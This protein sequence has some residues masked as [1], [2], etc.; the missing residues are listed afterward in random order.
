MIKTKSTRYL[1]LI[2]LFEIRCK[3]CN[4]IDVDLSSENCSE[5]G[6]CIS[7]ECN[8]CDSKYDYHDFK[9]INI[10]YDKSGDEIK[11]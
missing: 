8:N 9:Q 6:N 10:E 11:K 2:D 1:Y 3:K 5:C 7:A 4:S